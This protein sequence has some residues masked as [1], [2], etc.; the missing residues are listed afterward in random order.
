M[1]TRSQGKIPLSRHPMFA[2]I[3]AMWFAALLGIGSFAIRTNVLENA[4]LALR[5]DALVPAAVP[6]LGFT[7]RMLLALVV[8]LAGAALGYG[9]ARL[10]ARGGSAPAE[11]QYDRP[12]IVAQTDRP[13]AAE[14]A[15]STAGEDDDLARL[16]AAR[17]AL[18][19]RRRALTLDELPELPQQQP[20]ARRTAPSVL[21]VGD[22]D[23]ISPLAEPEPEAVAPSAATP[24]PVPEA[25]HPAPH[26]ALDST[27]AE[28]L[29]AAPLGNLGIAELIERFALALAA[30]RERQPRPAAQIEL[31]P[32][33]A[34]EILLAAPSPA[35]EAIAVRPAAPFI[36]D[37]APAGLTGPNFTE[38]DSRPFAMPPSLRQPGLG[39]IEWFDEAE[40]EATLE[41]L[42]PPKRPL[43][44]DPLRIDAAAVLPEIDHE[45]NEAGPDA[46][47]AE[48][49]GEPADDDGAPFSSLLDMK[50]SARQPAALGTFV[51]IE[52]GE[53][54]DMAQPVV[55]FPG[56][57]VPP[58]AVPARLPGAPFGASPVATEAA[59]REALSALQK[60][61]GTG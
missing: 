11:A 21:N 14:P 60:M 29:R 58:P 41:S 35:P 24:Q 43:T 52:D 57:M 59:L 10:V 44:N 22:L 49:A 53:A 34:P 46:D 2:P 48:I 28:R 38:P 9:L 8:M 5:I 31:S 19:Q 15:G 51:R 33:P 25:A 61:S 54:A 26:P 50:P 13:G 45:G 27:A 40:E 42:L 12:I 6:P 3:V 56:Q 16:A 32:P 7:A 18:P 47:V 37:A 4:V 36:D 30:R 39:N 55:V 17:S 23:A 1:T 20:L